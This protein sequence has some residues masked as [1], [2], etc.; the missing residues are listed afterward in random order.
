VV[1][2]LFLSINLVHSF[3][4]WVQLRLGG[5]ETEEEFDKSYMMPA[6][7]WFLFEDDSPPPT[8]CDCAT[9]FLTSK[10]M[11]PHKVRFSGRQR[12]MTQT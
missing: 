8:K 6:V 4:L 10:I 9:N 3:K 1:W 11:P 12:R 2:I 7:G 5:V